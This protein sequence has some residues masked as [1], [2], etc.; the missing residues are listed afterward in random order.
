VSTFAL[1]P[2]TVD[3][4]DAV[5]DVQHEGA[6][7]GLA[8][9]F[10]QETYPFP[11]SVVRQRWVEELADPSTH[12]YVYVCVG[13]TGALTGF[14]AT[15][16]NELLHFGTALRTWGTGT[17]QRFHEAVLAEFAHTAPSGCDHLRLRVFEANIRARRFYERLGW[18]STGHRSTSGFAPYAV[19]IE[20]ERPRPTPPNHLA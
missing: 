12:V 6:V 16:A 4:L 19:L 10:P 7:A 1:R 15:R 5:L 13:E 18:R 17:A 8:H 3:D 14:A 2:A 9:I 20:Y 11:R